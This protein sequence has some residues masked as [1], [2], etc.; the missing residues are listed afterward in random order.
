MYNNS[1]KQI[2]LNEAQT[3]ATTSIRKYLT[4]NMYEVEQSNLYCKSKTDEKSP[5]ELTGGKKYYYVEF[6]TGGEIKKL[7]FWD[8]KKYIKYISNGT[9]D[10]NDLTI[11]EIVEHD[12]TDMNC[13]N[14]LE[15]TN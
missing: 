12:N 11:D 10:V 5:I 15:K 3:V 1:K 6:E 13:E 14:V 8:N 9:R 7:I 4:E 2:F